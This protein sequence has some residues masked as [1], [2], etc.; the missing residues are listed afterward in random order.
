M[1]RQLK[2]WEKIFANDM[3]KKGL[4]SKY[5]QTA[6]KTQQNKPNQKNGQRLEQ[7]FLQRRQR[8]G[9]QAHEKMFNITNREMQI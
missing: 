7:I 3:T 8:G 9:Q 4:I 5:M 1:K 2:E 6:H